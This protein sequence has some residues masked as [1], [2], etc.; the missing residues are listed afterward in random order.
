MV[1]VDVRYE[2]CAEVDARDG[3]HTRVPHTL[4]FSVQ[5]SLAHT[6]RVCRKANPVSCC[7]EGVKS[8]LSRLLNT[9][10]HRSEMSG[11]AEPL[12][13]TD[14]ASDA[15]EPSSDL[16]APAVQVRLLPT[17][18]DSSNSQSLNNTAR[19]ASRIGRARAALD[20]RRK[21]SLGISADGGGGLAY[22]TTPIAVPCDTHPATAPSAAAP[23]PATDAAASGAV[24]PPVDTLVDLT[25][26][27]HLTSDLL[28]QMG[29]DA[30]AVERAMAE[31]GGDATRALEQLLAADEAEVAAQAAAVDSAPGPSAGVA[32][33]AQSVPVGCAC[34]TISASSSAASSSVA[35]SSAAAASSSVAAS[36]SSGG[37]E[38]ELDAL[39]LLFQMHLGLGGGTLSVVDG[40]CE[41]LGV[42]KRRGSVQQR[43]VR[44]WE[45]LGKPEVP[46]ACAEAEIAHGQPWSE[47]D[48]PLPPELLHEGFRICA[49]EAHH[50]GRYSAG[51]TLPH[52]PP[53]AGSADQGRG[54]GAS[55]TG[56]PWQCMACTFEHNT[57]L[58]VN[59]LA[60]EICA[61]PR[62]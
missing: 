18:D 12:L 13:G 57:A 20:R 15:P 58:N 1:A 59:F 61:T 31:S 35:S 22:D 47:T 4:T 54:G 39:M 40:A 49:D 50:S 8:I 51:A 19:I 27:E 2:G 36:F 42:P 21:I 56:A 37:D 23:P 29:F 41:L 10:T 62:P 34:P 11:A 9:A 45:T 3:L 43:A 55:A 33:P 32:A 28:K 26:D 25:E 53:V 30:P 38:P 6:L 17:H 60:C 48:S 14:S 16:S 44:C 24:S 7:S 46:P 5:R 52:P